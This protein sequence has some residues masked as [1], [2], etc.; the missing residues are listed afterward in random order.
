MRTVDQVLL[1]ST[2]HEQQNSFF[3]ILVSINRRRERSSQ[4]IKYII[5]TSNLFDCGNVRVLEGGLLNILVQECDI[6]GDNNGSKVLA[7][8]SKTCLKIAETLAAFLPM[9]R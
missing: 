7:L 5:A 4:E 1:Y 9:D 2:E 8:S 6:V 3:D